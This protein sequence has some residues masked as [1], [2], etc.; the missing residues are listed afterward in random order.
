M[1]ERALMTPIEAPPRRLTPALRQARL[2]MATVLS[3][4]LAFGA[5]TNPLRPLP[6]DLCLFKTL[7]GLPCLTCGLTRAVCLAIQGDF[8]GSL[9]M[10][11][12]GVIVLAAVVAWLGWSLLE[13]WQGRP[14][15][16]S[17]RRPA[18][19][20]AGVLASAITIGFWISEL[21]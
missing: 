11:P 14:L 7:T 8:A 15:W 2:R 21:S 19:R 4:L 5:L 10:H 13:A 20:F 3:G 6:I 1:S 12:A 9:A 18:I 17:G 16:E